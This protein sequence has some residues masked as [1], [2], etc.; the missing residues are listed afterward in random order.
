MGEE[1]SRLHEPS[2]LFGFSLSIYFLHPA[3]DSLNGTYP[4]ASEEIIGIAGGTPVFD[5]APALL[6]RQA[7]YYFPYDGHLNVAGAARVAAAVATALADSH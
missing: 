6:G 5:L 2:D 4:R 3:Q 7:R 1:F